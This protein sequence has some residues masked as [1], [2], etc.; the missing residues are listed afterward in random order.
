MNPLGTTGPSGGIGATGMQGNV[1]PEGVQGTIGV[2][3]FANNPGQGGRPMEHAEVESDR[4]TLLSEC[5]RG[6]SASGYLKELC[7]YYRKDHIAPGLQSAWLPDKEVFYVAVHRFP[8]RSVESR[9]IIAKASSETLEQA[10]A[11]C[12]SIWRKLVQQVE[13]ERHAKS[14]TN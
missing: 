5:K 6:V 14:G 12:M 11:D 13:A 8:T 2:I 4:K 1:G 7:E 10:E 3:D 9:L